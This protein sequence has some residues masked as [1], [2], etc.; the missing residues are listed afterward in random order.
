MKPMP[1]EEHHV[2]GER[3][4][5][6]CVTAAKEVHQ[7]QKI[8][9][10]SALLNGGINILANNLNVPQEPLHAMKETVGI[11][12]SAAG[13]KLREALAGMKERFQMLA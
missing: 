3:F 12:F 13:Y 11:M 6:T 9:F 8:G 7:K 2:S 1:I 5:D 4:A 10:D